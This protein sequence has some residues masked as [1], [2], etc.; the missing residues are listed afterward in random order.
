MFHRIVIID[1]ELQ[2]RIAERM[3]SAFIPEKDLIAE[4]MTD[5][6]KTWDL[7]EA[8]PLR[9]TLCIAD[10]GRGREEFET[11]ITRL[12]CITEINPSMEVIFTASEPCFYN[13]IYRVSHLFLLKKP[14]RPQSLKAALVK[15]QRQQSLKANVCDRK[16][17]VNSLAGTSILS[18]DSI[19]YVRKARRGITITTDRGSYEHAGRLEDFIGSVGGH[20]IRCH[21]SFVVNF[22]HAA[23]LRKESLLLDTGQVLA[24]SRPYQK[25]V[26][27]YADRLGIMSAKRQKEKTEEI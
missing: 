25:S 23:E 8:N 3:I 19:L 13:D 24:V 11:V 27:E 4:Y 14:F 6:E 5:R 18:L 21:S 15:Y 9:F 20:F 16:F 17:V 2:C 26:R 10:L 1:E 22:C 7:L 12:E